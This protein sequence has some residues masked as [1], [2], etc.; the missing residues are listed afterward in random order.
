MAN[1]SVIWEHEKKGYNGRCLEVPGAISEAG[2]LEELKANMT[3]AITYTQVH[4]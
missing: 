2:T 4:R 3:D 1:F